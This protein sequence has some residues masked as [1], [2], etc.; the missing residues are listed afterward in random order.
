[1]Q[2][3]QLWIEVIL[4]F[5][6]TFYASLIQPHKNAGAFLTPPLIVANRT[7]PSC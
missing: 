3:F 7:Y 4:V 2:G 5:V 6:N 1:M